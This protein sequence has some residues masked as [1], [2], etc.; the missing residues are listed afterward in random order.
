MNEK[1]L[2]SKMALMGFNM[3][4]TQEIK[5]ELQKQKEKLVK[6]LQHERNSSDKRR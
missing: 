1:R 2:K 4:T 6:E 3:K 5:D